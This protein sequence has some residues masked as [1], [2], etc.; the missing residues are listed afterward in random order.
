MKI[1]LFRA[2]ESFVLDKQAS[3]FSRFTIRNY[4]TTG[5]KLHM[6][7]D[8]DRDLHAIAR[9]DWVGFMFWIQNEYIPLLSP[10]T[11]ANVH[12]DLS[13]FYTWLTQPGVELVETHIF[14]TIDCPRYEKPR[15]ETFSREEFKRLLRACNETCP[16]HNRQET[17]SRRPTA[18]RDRAIL[19]LL[20]STG[21]HASE[22]C[23]LRYGDVNFEER[24]IYAEGKGRGRDSKKRM[25]YFGKTAHRALWLY[26][27]PRL[28]SIKN[29]DYVFVVDESGPVPRPLTRD[30]LYHLIAGIGERAGIRAYP[31]KFRH[32]FA[33]EFIRNG[34]DLLRLQS[35]LG[36]TS[37]E[38]VKRYTHLVASDCAAAHE[39]ADPADNWRVK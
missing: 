28:D 35:I 36:H 8:A 24:T 39:A 3:G 22:L 38:M 32:T 31:H 12:T 19:H 17:T 5:K 25:V 27:T 11:A 1:T 4:R 21:L 10:K 33:T 2:W 37:L 15:I 29:R 13:V 30:V 18:L 7:F 14:R 26:L 6:Y 34:G 23:E 20:L 9:S 16:W